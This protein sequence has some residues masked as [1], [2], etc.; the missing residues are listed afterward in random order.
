MGEG[1]SAETTR[2]PHADSV[3]LD[4]EVGISLSQSCYSV[5]FN[6]MGSF[7]ILDAIN[8]HAYQKRCCITCL[9]ASKRLGK[10]D[11]KHVLHRSK[12]GQS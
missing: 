11:S 9:K 6:N 3:V 2:C 12:F 7:K 4:L 1:A 5:S 10:V 8:P